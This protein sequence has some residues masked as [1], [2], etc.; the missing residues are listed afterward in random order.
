M[1][2][3]KR[4]NIAVL[5]ALG[6][7]LS[8]AAMAQESLERVEVTGSRIK[9][10][11]LEGISPVTVVS[12]KDIKADGV[13]NVESILNNLPQVFADQGGN[14]VNGSNGTAAV[15]LRGL[16]SDRTL[17]LVNGRRLP[18][19][20]ANSTSADLN[21][22]PA[23]LIK[24]IEVLTGGASAVYGSDAVAG[25]V[26]FI[27]N[28]RFEGV[29]FDV[30][31]SF[32]NHKQQ[33]A[34]GVADLVAARSLTNPKEFQ[35]PGNKTAD[36]KSTDVSLLLGSNFADNKG[37]ATLFFAYK[38]DDAL[39]Q[40]ERDFSACTVSSTAAGF[41][42]GG[43]GTNATGRIGI[44]NKVFTNA[45]DKGTARAFSNATD[46]Y[47]FGPVNFY[48]RPSERF[49]FNATGNYEV[50]DKAKVYAEFSFHDDLTV[51]QIAPGGAFI[52]AYQVKFE[53]PLL[54]DSWKA[55]MHANNIS[56]VDK[57][58]VSLGKTFNKPGDVADITMGRR[59]VEGGG[60]Q[61]EF[62]NTSF[63]E[64]IGVK[65]DVGKWSY[66]AYMIAAKVIYSQNEQNYFLGSRI[67]NAMD[68]IPD[69]NGKAVCANGDPA[70][71]PY[72]IWRLNGVD[73]AQLD[74]LQTPGFRKGGTELNVQGLSL[75]SDLGEYG[76]KLPTAKSGVGVSFGLEHRK[77]TLN[78]STDAATAAGDLSGSGGPT[79][80]LSGEYSVNEVF[81]EVRVPLIEGA[82]LAH[83]LSANGSY[84]YSDYKSGITTNT[85][86][87]GLEYAPVKMAKFRGAYQQAVR[88]PNLV[89]LFLPAGNN[90]YDNDEDPC[91]GA[92]P[93]ATLAQCAN[94][95]VTAAQYGNIQDSPA[96]QYNFLAGGNPNLKP[97]T[98]KSITLGMVLTPTRDLSLTVDY[99][100]IKIKDTISNIDPTTT[101][102]KC[103]ATGDATFCKLI[104]R[105]KLGTLWLLPEA[106]IVGT[107]QN[108]GSTKT[109]G[110]DFGA[111]YGIKL[112]DMGNLGLNMVG[113]WVRKYEVEELTGQ[114]SYD[115]VGL[116]GA[117]KC[118]TPTP[119]WRHKLRGTWSTP[120]AFDM[121]VTWRYIDKVVLQNTSDNP[122]LK[123]TTNDVDRSLAAQ[124]Y[125]DVS[126]SWQVTKGLTLSGGIN[127]LL[128]KDPPITSQLATGGGNGNTYPSVYDALGRKI[129]LGA[130]Y[131]F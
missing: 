53:N 77:E 121:A 115:C 76:I 82:P 4:I 130:S 93:T 66:D 90:L 20:S 127:N 30:N 95:G 69:A 65:G 21:Q 87:L 79:K 73:K 88:A 10:I 97:E 11:S 50:N 29:Q 71:V 74:Y 89:E 96:G 55:L 49:G 15:N 51:A 25:V 17:V 106:Q 104:N 42:C 34:G 2:Q 33:N 107:N 36:G 43:S 62:R 46:Q 18:M 22:I 125:L 105:D 14:V 68:V 26:N 6:S 56:L 5:V 83:M 120:W 118:G 103:L 1:F 126:A 52:D 114:G 113:T 48:Q 117:N 109:T 40:S 129:F 124:N 35:V 122:L 8:G 86:G 100:D 32:F 111:N 94:T 128:D 110:F 92:K 59:N 64:V 47:N 119:E 27:M 54:S 98:A 131:K 99:F 60:R 72:N 38:K 63:R 75:S 108:I 58:K 37:N 102:S 116:Y 13:R 23:Q 24:R 16:G 112:G 80:S 78:L 41:A 85:Y 57:D 61:S 19:G 7:T 39:L 67:Q 123:G 81:G 70:C 44:G 45:D 91:A 28:D 101:L 12:A 31:H 84:R 9:S 3:R